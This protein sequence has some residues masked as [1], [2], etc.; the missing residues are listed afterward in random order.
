MK[1]VKQTSSLEILKSLQNSFLVQKRALGYKYE[2]MEA[3][4][5]RFIRFVEPYE[6]K[7]LRLPQDIVVDY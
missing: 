3:S 2:V 1:D 5:K 7:S 6:L 4:I